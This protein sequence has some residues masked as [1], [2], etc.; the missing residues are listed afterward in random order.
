MS[1]ASPGGL[2]SGFCNSS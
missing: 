1:N 2:I